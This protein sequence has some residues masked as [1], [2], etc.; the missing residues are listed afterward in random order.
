HHARDEVVDLEQDHRHGIDHGVTD[1]VPD[2]HTVKRHALEHGGTDVRALHHLDHGG[3]DH[4]HDVARVEQHDHRH[5]EDELGG[6]G[7]PAPPPPG[8]RPSRPADAHTDAAPQEEAEGNLGMGRDYRAEQ[9]HGAAESG[10]L[11]HARHDAEEHG[12]RHD[13]GE[14]QGGEEGGVGES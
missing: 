6:D 12:K 4:A 1:G 2:H 9:D 3:A 11:A 5:G 13:A 10:G 14:G 8:R 7:P